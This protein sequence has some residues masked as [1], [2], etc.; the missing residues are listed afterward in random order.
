MDDLDG[1]V[2]LP[3]FF[4]KPRPPES[5]G[6]EQDEI[7]RSKRFQLPGWESRR[8]PWGMDDFIAKFVHEYQ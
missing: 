4:G 7:M 2:E 5:R 8:A 6:R 1:L 3:R